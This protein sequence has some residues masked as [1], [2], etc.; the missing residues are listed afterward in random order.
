MCY[1]VSAIE[2]FYG[3]EGGGR[4]SH[5]FPSK[6]FCLAVPTSFVEEPFIVSESFWCRKCLWIKNGG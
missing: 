6:F 5:N 1:K 4:E 2:N 3:F